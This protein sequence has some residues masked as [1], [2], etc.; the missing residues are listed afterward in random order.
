MKDI[1]QMMDIN[2]TIRLV[3]GAYKEPETIAFK[4][5]KKVDENFFK[6]SEFLLDKIKNNNWRAAF[7]THDI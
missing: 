5:K 7:A 2:P 6:L 1:V 4:S 3:K